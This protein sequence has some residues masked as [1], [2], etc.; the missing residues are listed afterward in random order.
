[1]TAGS[2]RS[3]CALTALLFLFTLFPVPVR[4]V[5]TSATAA[6]LVDE[7][8]GRVLYEKNADEKLRIAS[9]TKIM[10]ALVAIRD[11]NLSDVVTVSRRAASVEGSSMYLQSGEK[12]TLEALLYG[13]LLPSGND[14]A[15][16]IAEHVAGSEAAFVERMN[17][18]AKALGMTNSSFANPHGLDA[19][20]HYSTA[21]DMAKLGNAA[22]ELPVFRRIASTRTITI[23]KRTLKNHN[24]LL[25]MVEGCVGLKTGYTSRAGRTL[26]TC[27]ERD[28]RRLIAVTLHDSDDWT[29]HKNL[30]AYGFSQPPVE[31]S[32][33][34]QQAAA[35]GAYMG[36]TPVW[37]GLWST[38]PLMAEGDLWCAFPEGETV[39][40]RIELADGLLVA[41][42]RAGQKAGTA[43]FVCRGV[44]IGRIGVLCAV[45][46]PAEDGT[47]PA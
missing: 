26:V 11:G 25:D 13:L 16:A 18:T 12:L 45:T 3:V 44:E 40:V 46:I 17:E 8:G 4:A 15:T 1:M 31:L 29:D 36:E 43:V 19:E 37:K 35:A 38:V 41:P 6:I 7:T 42:L 34:V 14:A 20:G 39:S 9:T 23:G 33:P 32:G 2:K 47:L 28:G 22:M 21:R 5:D 24:K 27:V 30:Y 10:T